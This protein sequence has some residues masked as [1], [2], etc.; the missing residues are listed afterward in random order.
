MAKGSDTW[1]QAL[2]MFH[3]AVRCALDPRRVARLADVWKCETAR[4]HPCGAVHD[5]MFRSRRS[6][7]RIP[8]GTLSSSHECRQR[9]PTAPRPA[10]HLR[11]PG[12]AEVQHGMRPTTATYTTAIEACLH[13]S[14]W[15]EAPAQ[16]CGRAVSLNQAVSE[17][18]Q[19]AFDTASDGELVTSLPFHHVYNN[20]IAV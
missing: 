1:Q 18:G 15:T 7:I 13:G 6:A 12:C 17:M 4:F 3:T 9:Q 20:S 8:K 16:L 2:E 5:T 19:T 11:A 10:R 14:A